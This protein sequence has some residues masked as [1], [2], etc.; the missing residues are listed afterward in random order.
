MDNQHMKFKAGVEVVS[1][2]SQF[3]TYNLTSLPKHYCLLLK[4]FLVEENTEQRYEDLCSLPTQ[5][6]IARQ[7]VSSAA[8]LWVRATQFLPP[9]H[10]KLALLILFLPMA[11]T[12]LGVY[13]K[14]CET[15][16]L[17]L[18]HRQ[19]LVHVLNSCS[20][21]MELWHYMQLKTR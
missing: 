3:S 5:G 15:Y 2:Q 17:S 21:A 4:N 12:A 1:I 19:S 14:S 20:V 8:E 9:E 13:K 11:T 16:A 18:Q 10:T 6:D 7:L